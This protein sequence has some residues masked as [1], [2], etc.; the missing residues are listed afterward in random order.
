LKVEC[1]ALKVYNVQNEENYYEN[2]LLYNNAINEVEILKILGGTDGIIKYN[3]R[4]I[5]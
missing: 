3:G 5:I 2:E 1:V 4:F